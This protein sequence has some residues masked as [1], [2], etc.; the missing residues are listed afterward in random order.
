MTGLA[1]FAWM[2][3]SSLMGK[4]VIFYNETIAIQIPLLIIVVVIKLSILAK[5]KFK[6]RRSLFFANLY[7]YMAYIIVVLVIDFR[8]LFTGGN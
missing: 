4:K 6:T 3:Y 7:T 2:L 5:N 8:Y 1:G